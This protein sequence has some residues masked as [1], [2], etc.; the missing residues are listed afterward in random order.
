MK[1]ITFMILAI[2][3]FAFTN[4]QVN[5]YVFTQTAGTFTPITGGTVLVTP[6]ADDE[7]YSVV[8]PTAFT[9]NGVSYTDV[10]V[11]TNGFL[12]FGTTN[13]DTNNYTPLSS[14]T[15]Y[16]GAVAGYGRDLNSAGAGSE[17]RWE[18]LGDEIIFQWLNVRRYNVTGEQINFQIRLNTVNSEVKVVYGAVVAGS[19]TTYAQ[20]GLR[21]ATNADFNNRS[22]VATTG[23][24]INSTTGVANTS[25]CYIN[26]SN[27][28]TIP[29]NGLTYTWSLPSCLAP[30]NFTISNVYAEEV[31]LLWSQ[32]GSETDWQ[33]VVQAPGSGVPSS[34]FIDTDVN[35]L[36]HSGLTPATSYE[37]YIRSNCGGG[38]FSSWIGPINFTTTCLPL[39]T[40][41]HAESFDAATNP[42]CWSTALLTGVTNWAPDDE[43]DGVPSART[44]ARF[45][46]KS[47]VGNDDA[48]LISPPY[49]L[50]G[51]ATEQA[52]LNVWIYRSSNGLSTD[53]TT[54]YVNTSSNLTGALELL[55]IPLP[56]S[57]TPTVS[58]A[59][60]YN[61]IVEIP[62]SY[63]TGGEFFVIARGR[64]SSS[65]SSYGIGFDDYLLELIPS[66]LPPS[67]FTISNIYAEEV[68]LL[69]SQGD[70]ETDWQYV[71]QEPG[72]G[73]PSSDFIDTDVNSLTHSGLT[74]A[75]SYEIYIR[76]D[77][78]GG[79]FSS[80]IGPINFTTTCLPLTT[81]PHAESFDAATNPS[82]WTTTLLTGVTNW[83][84]DDENDGVPSARTG[85]RF[86]GKSW[87]GNDDALLISPP[88]DLS[89]YATEQARLNVWI[90]R[91]SNG[92]STDRTTFYV[93]TSSNLTGALELL[94]IPLPISAAPSVSTA[95]WY[96]YIVEIPLSYNTG[97]EFFVIARGRTSSSFSS[98]GIGFDDYLLQLVPSCPEPTNLVVTNL[99]ATSADVTW[100]ATTGEYE[101][102]LDND[103]A[104]PSGSGESISGEVYNATSLTPQTTYYFHVRSDCESTW[105]TISFTT[106]PSN[107]ECENAIALT[108]NEDFAC[109]V[110]TAG[111]IVSAT[112]SSQSD[113]VTGTPDNDVWFSFVATNTS[114]RISLLNLVAVTGFSTDMGIGLYDATGGCSSL[115]L[116]G[117]SDPETYN[118]TGLT[119]G[120]TYLVR[121]YGWSSGPTTQQVNFNICIGTPTP[122][123]ANDACSGAFT[124]SSLPYTNSQDA[125]S[126]T[127]NSGFISLC[128][129][130]NDGVWYTVIGNGADIT[131]ELINVVGWDPEI[132]VYSGSCGS[133][134]CVGSADANGTSAGETYTITN[135]IN[136][137]TYYI[138]V[139]YWSGFTNSSEGPFTINITTNLNSDSFN[140]AAFK[141]YPNPVKDI[142]NFEYDSDITS[143]R[144][145][146][147]LGQEVMVRNN[148][149]T[150]AQMDISQLPAGTYIVNV[151]VGDVLKTVKISK[152]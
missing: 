88:Y 124:A 40:L 115:V 108:V 126:A 18:Q 62:L 38:D 31:D 10:R 123:P 11:S 12:T 3:S 95:G 131:I 68:D 56:I 14:T 79:D 141:V 29:S 121:V 137:T 128:G 37:I 112:A 134:T 125:S 138:N 130:M 35:S 24:W 55:D 4:A 30:T 59:G 82:C 143:I 118:V 20:V 41:P 93:N 42:S 28:S 109:D 78:G 119:I 50:S 149:G 34:G 52:R 113:D 94:D 44:G 67:N 76:S 136:G 19:N 13:P 53:R 87:V 110:V 63:N 43:N 70:S 72:S 58:T 107:D 23:D 97:G 132:G 127:N 69:W 25:T 91:S 61:Y 39:T 32:G 86:S 101:Y 145:I 140:N 6:S 151:R 47:W 22:V 98:Y 135:S 9:F 105:S 104:E 148:N 77:C 45:S 60:W 89:G 90:Y 57:A 100:A 1:K 117:S 51:Y 75:T 21:G 114:H 142:L 120:T 85:A 139:G 7:R 49:D 84:P 129:G 66:C 92:L 83:A 81:L 48:L 116:V 74:P 80:W 64:T 96:N 27:P 133:F 26:S 71:V 65:F 102:V 103:A 150:S 16:G 46:G 2:F 33:Y 8:L 122:P 17:I 111:T 36:T 147:L 54:F 146:N 73:V 106:P 152:Q 99:T 144:I 15:A 5:G